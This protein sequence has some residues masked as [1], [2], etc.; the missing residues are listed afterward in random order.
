MLDGDDAYIGRQVFRLF[1][2][3]YQQKSDLWVAYTTYISTKFTY[4]E[5]KPINH[6]LDDKETGGRAIGHYIGPVRT[7]YVKLIQ[8]IPLMYHQFKNGTWLDT[9]S[10]DA[11]Q[12]SFYELAGNDRI[13]YY[14][15][16]NYLYSMDY[17]NNDYST[18]AKRIHRDNTHKEMTSLP[19]NELLETLDQEFPPNQEIL[20]L[21]EA[22]K[23]IK[24]E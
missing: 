18:K 6:R 15:E 2:A 7:W 4:G 20:D 16:I 17:G 19:R 24:F 5:S 1:N 9:M 23:G 13:V 12:Y 8:Q 22:E 3:L 21:F 10:D 11:L 14:P